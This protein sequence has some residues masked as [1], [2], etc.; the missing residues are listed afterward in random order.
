MRG[1]KQIGLVF[2][3]LVLCYLQLVTTS[4]ALERN[5]LAKQQAHGRSNIA[6]GVRSGAKHLLVS[7]SRVPPIKKWQNN[8]RWK[9][10]VIR[11]A[12]VLDF[13]QRHQRRHIRMCSEP[14]CTCQA[15]MPS[16][17][18]W[19]DPSW[20]THWMHQINVTVCLFRPCPIWLRCGW[21]ATVRHA[22]YLQRTCHTLGELRGRSGDTTSQSTH[23]GPAARVSSEAHCFG[24][25]LTCHQC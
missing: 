3:T 17:C 4:L 13:I 5:E 14:L 12:Q 18:H 7:A 10:H 20:R 23:L 25:R 9:W 24:P 16:P 8:Q 19:H 15:A 1:E 21:I 11:T 6:Q 22:M 2:L